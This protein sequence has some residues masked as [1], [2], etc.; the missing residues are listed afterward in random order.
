M[1]KG[2]ESAASGDKATKQQ[3]LDATVAL[4]REEGIA[5][6]TLRR[7]AAKAGSNLALVNYYYNSKDNLLEEATRV[8]ISGFDDAFGALENESLP[9]RERLLGFFKAYVGYLQ[10]YPGL[11]KQMVDQSGSI[12]R[13]I[14]KYSQYS[15]TIKRQKMLETL[16][17]I[18]GVTDEK[19]LQLMMVQLQGA[20]LV[21]IVMYPCGSAGEAEVETPFKELP[22]V[23]EQIEFLFDHYFYRYN[24]ERLKH[25]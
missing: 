2:E 11:A 20:V 6:L 3:I 25:Q 1:A 13:S 16:S 24:Q 8:L 19:R 17:G 15:K 7:I 23:D 4:I 21:P 18:S 5:G 14:H 22:S 10:Q 9:P 12:L